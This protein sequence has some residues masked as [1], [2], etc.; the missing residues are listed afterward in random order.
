MAD[1]YMTMLIGWVAAGCTTMSFVP[2]LLKIRRQG[3][4]DLSD[5]MLLLYL[6]GLGLW[7]AYGVRIRAVEVIGANIIGGALVLAALVMKRHYVA[8]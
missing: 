2:Q 4:R 5:G 3:G 7:L 1:N 6:L 8:R